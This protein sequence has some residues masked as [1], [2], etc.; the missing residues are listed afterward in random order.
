MA[1]FFDQFD[2]PAPA[3][4]GNFFDQFDEV[5]PVAPKPVAPVAPATPEF[6]DLAVPGSM[7]PD[8]TIVPGAG[9]EGTV[10]NSAPTSA[11]DKFRSSD[12]L[13]DS[14]MAAG[15]YGL[16][17][18][19]YTAEGARKGVSNVAGL[20]V[21][22]INA[23]PMLANL[24]P[25]VDGVGPM[26]EKPVGGSKFLGDI[27]SAGGVVPALPETN[28][29]LKQ[30]FARVG[31]EIGAASVPML[32]TLGATA[33]LTAAEARN[34]PGV[35]KFFG[36]DKAAVDPAKFVAD[37]L[38][39]ATG[40]GTGAAV[41][42]EITNNDRST[43]GGALVDAGGA[44][45]GAGA[46]GVSTALL[47]SGKDLMRAIF[48][49]GDYVDEV[50]KEAVTDQIIRN[51]G[52]Q[53]KPGDIVDTDPLVNS[54]MNGPKVGDT[55]PGFKESLAD[56]TKIPG[57]A[58]LEYAQQTGPN[59]GMYA[60]QRA[61]NTAAV[62]TAMKP[63][64]PN[65]TPGDFAD[66]AIAERAKRLGEAATKADAAT[67]AW[68][69]S[70]R[71]LLPALTAEGRGA[72]I[73]TALQD[74]SDS[75][76]TILGQAW[77]P[78]NGSKQDVDMEALD[79]IFRGTD[80]NLSVAEMRRFRPGEADIPGQFIDPGT[81]E[82]PTGILDAR[83]KP[84]M[85]AAIPP[86]GEA[87]LNE[88]TGIRSALTDAAREATTAGKV[89]EARVIGQYI[90]GIDRYMQ[91]NLPDDLRQQYETARAATVDFNDRFTR[92]QTA[93]GQ[94]LAEREGM[95]RYP[96]STVANKFVQGDQG[97]IADF[98][99][100]MKEAGSD[101]RVQTAVRD[102][103]LQDVKDRGLLE[104]PEAL[105]TYLDGY[106]NVFA[107]FPALKAQL[108]DAKNLRAEMDTAT[109]A[110]TELDTML[111]KQGK[112]A[113][114]NYLSYSNEN[115]DRAMRGV[116]AAKDPKKAIDELLTFVGDDAKAVEGAR[117]TFWDIMQK[118][119]RSGGR[120]TG[121]VNG[122]Q[123][124]S[125]YSLNKFLTDPVNSAVLD[126]LYRDNPTHLENIRQI[127]DAIQGTE[128]RNSA[129]AVNTSGTAQGVNN[130]LTPE[131]IQS[132]LYAYKSGKISGTFLLTSIFAVV[133]RRS[134][135]RAQSEGITR[136]LDEVLLDPEKA[137]ILLKE[138]NPANR[139][140]LNRYAKDWFGNEAS[141]IINAMSGD[142]EDTETKTIMGG[143]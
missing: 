68:E 113:V 34:L 105:Q 27:L 139:R 108:G 58:A 61:T 9:V 45:A 53:K 130:V 92:P 129:K 122:A 6:N 51:S 82:T 25:G 40:A 23:A 140:A 47:G 59:A 118:D 66:V 109:T 48:G 30:G 21:D 111:N 77:A 4:G 88:I 73:R 112:S 11:Y 10:V 3:K 106:S 121:D 137:A 84:I 123:P 14:I 75:A 18:G 80:S 22:L 57:I 67:K 74:A 42:N 79:A 86:S 49:S 37:E 99:A 95:P 19:G 32:G 98:E 39:L 56:R 33:K 72:N 143:Q 46:T 29:P 135:G 87:P 38:R 107:K 44:L 52:L 36:A 69:N 126:R 132:R 41:V 8:G 50:V 133:A 131:T 142:D 110:S 115:A 128:I 103:I 104:K 89:N 62:D 78:I 93:I 55:V 117:K 125:P 90:D 17:L 134:V 15:E 35:A 1:N 64:E 85:K 81:P 20:P 54:I 65:A 31:E 97:R 124:W 138:N 63:F 102:Q 101:D 83:G 12:N 127:A 13:V 16:E 5:P 96:D 119:A 71:S 120:T 116:L 136:M 2:P 24:L 26:S 76:K 60:A 94:T 70:T 141:S 91:N 43:A 7:R 114:A 100:L 28:D